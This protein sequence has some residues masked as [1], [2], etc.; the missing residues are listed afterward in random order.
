LLKIGIT[1]GIGSG[2]SYVCSILEHLGFPVFY[3]DK[4]AKTLI[5]SDSI[6]KSEFINLFGDEI[7]VNNKL[8]KD[9]ISNLIFLDKSLLEKVNSVVHP[10]VR[11]CFNEWA[12]SQN[13]AIVFNEAAIL[14]ETNSYKS[15]DYTVLIVAPFDLK[16]QRV[17]KRDSCTKEDV[18]RRMENQWSDKKKSTLASFVINNNDEIGLISQVDKI[19]NELMKLNNE[20]K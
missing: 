8:D 10:R 6:I 7:Y 17:M 14:F 15:F 20:I 2:K 16:I 4:V 1:G 3:S 18:L 5:E 11:Q 13:V 9:R 19:V 12:E